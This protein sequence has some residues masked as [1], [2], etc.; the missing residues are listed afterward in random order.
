MK[1]LPLL[2]AVSLSS[3]AAADTPAPA[4]KPP[5]CAAAEFHQ[6]DFWI[7]DWDVTNPQGKP[8]GHNRIEAV[9]DGCAISEHWSGAS[10]TTGKSYSAWD[11]SNKR[12]NQY[13][14]DTDGMVLYLDGA[15][16]D[17][18]MVMRGDLVDAA[19]GKRSPQR[20]TWTPNA[21]GTVHQL[22]Q[23]SDDG[24]KTWQTVFEGN[25]RRAAGKP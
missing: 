16:A 15:F 19:S 20:V 24:G 7:G 6:F 4:K 13:W 14:V 8:A 12:W 17:G 23:G 18:R 25:Y 5:A 2:I 21:D 9:L 1:S 10:G 11:A 3:V 22:W